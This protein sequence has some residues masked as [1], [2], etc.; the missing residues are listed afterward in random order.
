MVNLRDRKRTISIC[1]SKS[2]PMNFL[3]CI[4]EGLGRV[5]LSQIPEQVRVWHTMR[6]GI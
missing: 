5:K 6:V 4:H 1:F 3:G 2:G